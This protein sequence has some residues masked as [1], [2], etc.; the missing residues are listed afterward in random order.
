MHS[1]ALQLLAFRPFL[2]PIHFERYWFLLI[3]PMALG[4]S[5]AY[6]AVRVPDM[7]RFWPQTLIMTVQIVAG[8]IALGTF[9]FV[10]VQYILPAIA[11]R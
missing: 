9:T 11:L 3:I 1:T 7:R 10:F 6:K 8:M 4:V 2:D 5:L